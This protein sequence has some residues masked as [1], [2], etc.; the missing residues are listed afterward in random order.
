[1]QN[2]L[3]P[4]RGD[5]TNTV[6]IFNNMILYTL[7]IQLCKIYPKE[8]TV[9]LIL[10]EILIE[11]L[12]YLSIFIHPLHILHQYWEVFLCFQMRFSYFKKIH[13]LISAVNFKYGAIHKTNKKL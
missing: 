12:G 9:S 10:V 4:W 1:M 8:R 13:C 5:V 2:Y 11:S 3:T 7:K 6:L